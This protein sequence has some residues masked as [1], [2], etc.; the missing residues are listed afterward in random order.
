MS[1]DVAKATEAVFQRLTQMETKNI[2]YQLVILTTSPHHYI[3]SCFDEVCISLVL[4]EKTIDR[5]N[6]LCP[7]FVNLQY[8]IDGSF[9]TCNIQM[10]DYLKQHLRIRPGKFETAAQ[11]DHE[12][13]L[14]RVVLSES[15]GMG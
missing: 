15:A 13:S 2:D 11:I 4:R 3:T 1:F 5:R 8:Q 10:E 14:V 6:I 12:Q 9:P 7:F